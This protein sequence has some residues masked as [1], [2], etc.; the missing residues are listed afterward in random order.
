[1]QGTITLEELENDILSTL[2]QSELVNFAGAPLWAAATSPEFDQ[3][4]VDFR[5]NQA[6]RKIC[7]DVSDIDV[8][9]FETS[10]LSKANTYQYPIQPIP[11][12]AGL[13][14][15]PCAEVRRL[16]YSPV[17]F[18][19]TLEHEPSV[20]MLP[21]KEFQ[22]YTAAGYLQPASF[23]PYPEICSITPDRKYLQFYPGSAN[24][25]DTIAVEYSCVPTAGTLAPLLVNETDVM[26]IPDD[27]GD[28]V[29][30][31]ALYKLWPKARAMGAAKES[32]QLYKDQLAEVRA[33]WKHRS[34]GDK[35][36]ITDSLL[37]RS[38]SGPWGWT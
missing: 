9:M 25:G 36:R 15:P 28:L 29:P 10:F 34:G 5:I 20:R 13:P 30:I 19:F 21:W 1:M 11:V 3:P 32:L 23:G 17:G 31:Y 4:T 14:N 16:F 22:R 8:A 26:I 7:R 38:T 27:F 18:P 12:T 35:Q 37:D 6:Y 33:A 2:Q 24:A